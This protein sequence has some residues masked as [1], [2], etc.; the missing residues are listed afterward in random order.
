MIQEIYDE[1]KQTRTKRL[2]LYT[3]YDSA[4]VNKF[5]ELQ[6]KYPDELF[7]I[8][9][10]SSKA[11]DLNEFSKKFFSK[12]ADKTVDL[13]VDGNANV[14]S[15]T[16]SQYTSEH[17]KANQRLNGLY[18][19]WKFVKKNELQNNEENE[20]I[21]IANEAIEKIISGEIF[22]NDLNM[23]ERP[24]CWAQSLENLVFEGAEFLNAN[25][26]VKPPKR[27]YSFI[28]LVIQSMAYMSNQ[29]AGAIAFPDLFFYFDWFLRNEYGNDYI[30][31][32]DFKISDKIQF[33]TND[34]IIVKNKNSNEIK[35][36]SGLDFYNNQ[37]TYL[38]GE[39][40]NS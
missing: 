37:N 8:Q 14:Y 4:F 26:K 6:K 7:N 13:T 21:E 1:E 28:Q 3:S 11:R 23:V 22:V 31:I 36:I 38:F 25:F 16:V 29:L 17:N 34:I 32:K 12:S 5:E 35:E 9:G 20:A 24:Y 15:K 19:L 27:S 2:V 39:I 30:K 10:I 33:N 18:L 40:K